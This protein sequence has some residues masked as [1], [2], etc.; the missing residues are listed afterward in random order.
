M[1]AAA[2]GAR[3]EGGRVVGVTLERGTGRPNRWLDE[4]H[5]QPDLPARIM[6]LLDRG[7]GYVVLG[8]GTGTLAEIGMLLELQNKGL[9][10]RR[11]VVFLGR[12]WRPL[13]ELL[14]DEP[15]L[16]EQAPFQPVEGA[17]MLGLVA[18]TDSP[19]A[20]ARYLAHNLRAPPAGQR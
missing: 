5:P 6:E 4:V 7:D 11:P 10:P 16:R 2:R 19:E 13:L 8:G 20:A 9:V 12:F 3:Q 15:L 18:C 1:E 17:E 14:R